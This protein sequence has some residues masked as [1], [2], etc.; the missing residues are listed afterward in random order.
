[1]DET[2][3]APPAVDAGVA[4]PSP[5]ATI[6]PRSIK[7]PQEATAWLNQRAAE[8]AAEQAARAEAAQGKTDAEIRLSRLAKDPDFLRRYAQG[9]P[10]AR[11]EHEALTQ[12]IAAGDEVGS[13]NVG[14]VEVVGE[15]GV[16]RSDLI[17]EIDRLSRLGIPDEGVVKAITGDFTPEDIAWAQ[18]ELDK[19]LATREWVDGLLRG[20]PKI[21]HERTALC[22]VISAGKTL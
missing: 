7:T 2:T 21:L 12:E 6:D 4:G 11:R 17:S 22:A 9:E 1:M 8:Y 20:D 14:P 13:V 10:A 19:C 5:A 3:G 18:T 15:F 16:R